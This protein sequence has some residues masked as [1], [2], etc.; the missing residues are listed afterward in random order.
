MVERPRVA[1]INETFARRY[2]PTESA[3][4]RKLNVGLDT[5]TI[6]GV[7]GW[8]GC[9]WSSIRRRRCGRSRFG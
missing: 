6:V 5:L 9:G 7:V 3:I 1:V 4:G 2:W 8:R